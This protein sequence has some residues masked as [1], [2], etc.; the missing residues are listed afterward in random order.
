MAPS[1]PAVPSPFASILTWSAAWP[2]WQRDAL[3]RIVGSGPLNADAMKELAAICRAKHGLIAAGDTVPTAVCFAAPHTPG[4]ADDTTSV[5]LARLSGLQNVGR[6]A[7]GSLRMSCLAI[8]SSAIPARSR[9]V[10]WIGWQK[11]E[12]K[13]GSRSSA[14]GASASTQRRLTPTPGAARTEFPSQLHWQ[15]GCASWKTRSRR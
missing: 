9:W 13:T 7:S 6:L 5:S 15:S 14:F 10:T 1:A 8:C 4:G 11:Y 3:R 12:L 2:D